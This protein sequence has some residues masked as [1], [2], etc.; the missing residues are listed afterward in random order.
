MH[1]VRAASVI[2]S[3]L[4]AVVLGA[5]CDSAKETTVTKDQA[6]A[7]VAERAQEAFRQLPPGA[8]L[9][10]TL[11]T[12]DLPCDDGDGRVFVETR[13]DVVFPATWP[14]DQSMTV[15]A[16]YWTGNGYRIVRD[17][18]ASTELP[19]LVA[20]KTSDGFRIGYLINHGA[21]GRATA[22]LLSSS[23]CLVSK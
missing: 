17:D 10:Q 5:G 11:H 6:V 2:L 18:R 16:D 4:L 13:Y 15:L 23:P 7:R 22:R 12:P 8:T 21:D 3:G 1:P 9:E 19:E 20:E 14:V